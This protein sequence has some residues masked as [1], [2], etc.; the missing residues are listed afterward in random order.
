MIDWAQ[1]KQLEDD[2]GTEDFGDVVVLFLEEV[3][4]A[5]NQ[6]AENPPTDAAQMAPALH[7]LKGSAYNLGFS[8]FA[9]Y[10]SQGE[11]LAENGQAGDVDLAKVIDLYG[12]SKRIFM[13]E[14]PNRCSFQ[15]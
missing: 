3:D 1:I 9:E 4:E 13:S 2:I 8:A 7:F 6:L 12:E 15:P 10:C 5:V 11:A 14:A